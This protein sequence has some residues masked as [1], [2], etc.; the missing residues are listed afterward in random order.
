MPL[1]GYFLHF[2]TGE[3]QSQLVGCRVEKVHQPAKYEVMLHL[4][5]YRAAY[6]LFLSASPN[7]PRLHITSFAPENPAKP[8]M[9]CMLLRKRLLGA[10]LRDVTQSGLDR[11]VFL[12]FDATNEIG[13]PVSLRLCVEIMA[14][15]SNIILLDSGGIILDAVKRVDGTQSSYRQVLPGLPYRSPPP[16]DKLDL[17]AC[18]VGDVLSRLRQYTDKTLPS[19]LLNT[20]QGASP[21]VCRELASR[22]GGTDCTV[23]ELSDVQTKLLSDALSALKTTLSTG[24]TPCILLDEAGRGTD[25]SFMDVTQ[26]GFARTPKVYESCCALLDD[27]YFERDRQD[28]TRQRAADMLKALSAAAARTAR[29]LDI[30]R[31][32]LER[33]ADRETLRIRG[34]LIQ[35]YAGTLEKGA[36]FYDV[37]NYYDGGN[38]VRIAV[39]PALA[40]MANAQKYYKEYRKAKTAEQMLRTLIE[41]GEQELQYLETL[42]DLVSRA[43]AGAELGALRAEIEQAGYLK[44]S[45]RPNEKNP[46]P[47]PPLEYRST[48][49]FRILV[50]RNNLQND[51][52]SLKTARG[53]DLWLHTQKIPG[54][55]VIVCAEGREIPPSTIEQAAMIA[56]YNSRARESAQVPV[57]YTFAKNLKKPPGAKPG[58][59]IYH[60]YSTLTINPDRDASESLRVE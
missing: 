12:D 44:H 6:K 8:P 54:S 16:Q 36:P 30:Q 10:K 33:C 45:R 31:A 2:L 41:S 27:F 14:K 37:P 58:K 57:D 38:I 17:R 32:E 26:Y 25:F 15:H 47:L 7:S 22:C 23:R 59:V 46:K 4:R 55:H 52:L 42:T 21:L 35:S 39:D 18:T 50:G 40:P 20:L 43:D 28:R 13:D 49:G 11:T 1:D 3:L 60:V 19:A 51:R 24:G 9:L 56:A 53:S 48:D 34:E 5:G 29:K